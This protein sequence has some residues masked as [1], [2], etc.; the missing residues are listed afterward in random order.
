LLDEPAI[1]AT[2]GTPKPSDE[3]IVRQMEDMARQ[4]PNDAAEDAKQPASATR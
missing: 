4:A 3:D 2:P 1:A